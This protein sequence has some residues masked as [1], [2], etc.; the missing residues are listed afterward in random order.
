[1]KLA[2]HK[3]LSSEHSII[4]AIKT[5]KKK[6]RAKCT[7]QESLWVGLGNLGI[8][9]SLLNSD[10]PACEFLLFFSPASPRT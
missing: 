8:K 1:M 4:N 6:N 9:D 7:K 2:E 5:K 3:P 10:S